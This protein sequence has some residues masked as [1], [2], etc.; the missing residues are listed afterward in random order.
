MI[1]A[2]TKGVGMTSQRTR[3]RLIEQ[4]KTQ[5]I[6]DT[7]VLNVIASCP[8]HM[9]IDEALS[10]C[11]YDNMSLPIGC[12]QTISQPYIVA[13][14]TEL[15]LQKQPCS[16]VLEIGTGSGYQAAVLS[17][18]IDEVY[19][20]E[21][22]HGLHIKAK[23]LFDTLGLANITSSHRDGWEGWPE[24]GLY[25]AIMVTAAPEQVPQNL[26]AQLIDGGQLILPLGPQTAQNLVLIE[27]VGQRYTKKVFEPVRFVPMPEGKQL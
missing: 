27:R 9:F 25:D 24:H 14:M 13:R 19:T 10:H 22:I 5:G 21:R 23:K 12:Q 15:L 20:L 16:K 11:A 18:L 1:D 26:I 8:R 6:K 4:L 3:L 7:R 17:S 2:E